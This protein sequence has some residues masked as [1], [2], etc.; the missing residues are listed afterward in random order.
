[1]DFEDEQQAIVYNREIDNKKRYL[2]RS[3]DELERQ[4]Q[5]S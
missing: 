2:R 3:K 1:V 5:S 4:Y